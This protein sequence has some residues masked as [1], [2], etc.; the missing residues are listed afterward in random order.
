MHV[1]KGPCAP[2]LLSGAIV[3]AGITAARVTLASDL[4]EQGRHLF[5]TETLQGNGRTCGTCHPADNNYT[6]DPAYIARLPKT[7]PLFVAGRTPNSASSNA[8]GCCAK[9][10]LI[11]VHADGF[12]KPGVL[13]GVPTL[14]GI[15]GHWRSNRVR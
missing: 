9:R 3:F 4:I 6:I 10:R 5:F 14:L 7:D 11:V 1:L 13:R 12:G 15:S 8:L 2:L